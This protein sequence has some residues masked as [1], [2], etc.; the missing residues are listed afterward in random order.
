[1][2]VIT[3]NSSCIIV[4]LLWLCQLPIFVFSQILT[5]SSASNSTSDQTAQIIDN[6]EVDTDDANEIQI[7]RNNQTFHS[8]SNNNEKINSTTTNGDDEN[9]GGDVDIYNDPFLGIH[10]INF[11]ISDDEDKNGDNEMYNDTMPKHTTSIKDEEIPDGNVTNTDNSKIITTPTSIDSIVT[12]PSSTPTTRPNSFT[13]VPIFIMDIDIDITNEDNIEVETITVTGTVDLELINTPSLMGREKKNLFLD[14]TQAFLS[15]QLFPGL[16]MPLMVETSGIT[17][18]LIRQS[19]YLLDDERQRHRRNTGSVRYLPITT[20]TTVNPKRRNLQQQTANIAPLY[21]TIKVTGLASLAGQGTNDLEFDEALQKIFIEKEVEYVEALQI[22]G[23][24]Y[25]SSLDEASV[26]LESSVGNDNNDLETINSNANSNQTQ[27]ND[28][29]KNED[30]II[31]KNNDDINTEKDSDLTNNPSTVSA[32]TITPQNNK[33]D[34]DIN[35]EKD[36]DLTNNPSTVPAPTITPQINKFD[37]GV[38]QETET[39]IEHNGNLDESLSVASII[40][41]AIG[42]SVFLLLA[43]FLVCCF[44]ILKG[45][46]K[47]HDSDRDNNSVTRSRSRIHRRNLSSSQ[48]KKSR[49]RKNKR[50]GIDGPVD[51]A[52]EQNLLKSQSSSIKAAHDD[53]ES[54]D[55]ASND[56]VESQ[57]M[58]SYNQS[59][60][61]S[62]S[63]YT[64][65]NNLKIQTN[66]SYN[67][68]GNDNM[69]Y[70]YSLEPGIEASVFDGV[71][72]NDPSTVPKN[73]NGD[74]DDMPIREIPN[75]SVG[76]DSR[77]ANDNRMNSNDE[78][79]SSQNGQRSSNIDIQN[80]VGQATNDGRFG[81]IQIETAPSELRLTESELKMLPSNLKSY[82]DVDNHDEKANYI[83]QGGR[84]SKDNTTTT[85]RKV[86]APDGKLGIVID[87]T[88]EGPIVHSVNKGSRLSGKIFPSDIIIAI[89]NVDTRAMSAKAITALMVKTMHQ[90]RTLT[91]RGLQTKSVILKS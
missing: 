84:S 67:I 90:T 70:A 72:V 91:V 78:N 65:G 46:R 52:A 83:F 60:G 47:K 77:A 25:F 2:K 19:R 10:L 4:A 17:V 57:A 66:H 45:R 85:I 51:S 32:P 44:C 63:V 8:N 89:D 30:D 68:G 56:D 5:T 6:Q 80:S 26:V 31:S 9:G 21:V 73:K 48:G 64:T 61:D 75:I 20:R 16:L 42:V 28:E 69:S 15:V 39:T 35:T 36:P 49:N 12:T 87:T 7:S 81:D 40:G 27:T 13:S 62:G 88:V 34:D 58:Y 54:S 82:D 55:H 86:Q 18:E 38:V 14:N 24:L 41:I 11:I 59:R 23:D 50:N 33:F 37:E 53:A 43:V 79:N 71:N 1:M 22:T 3:S 74:T 76:T 29:S